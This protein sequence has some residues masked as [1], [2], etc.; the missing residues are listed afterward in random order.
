MF[1]KSAAIYDA[2]HAARFDAAVAASTVHT[3]ILA[4]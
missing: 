1:T 3:L 4:H 2:I